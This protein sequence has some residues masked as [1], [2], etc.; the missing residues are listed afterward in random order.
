MVKCS[1]HIEREAR[2]V[3]V[4]AYSEQLEETLD[5]YFE[6]ESCGRVRRLMFS[7]TW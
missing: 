5:N 6:E 1:H 7:V 3:W 2:W 4:K